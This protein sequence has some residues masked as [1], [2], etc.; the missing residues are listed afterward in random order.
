MLIKR[1]DVTL[2]ALRLTQKDHVRE[3]VAGKVLKIVTVS[4]PTL[5]IPGHH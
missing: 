1:S 5:Y 3:E 4:F 2:I